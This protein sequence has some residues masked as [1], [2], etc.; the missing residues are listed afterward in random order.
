[1][2][3][4]RLIAE[5]SRPG[6][7]PFAVERIEVRQTHISVVF[8]A[9]EFVYKVKKPVALGFL[10]FST[11]EK[12]RHFC[13]EEVRLNRRLAPD[14]YLGVVPV[15]AGQRGLRFEGEGEP[16]EWAVKMCRL[17]E[18]ATLERRV[19]SGQVNTALIEVLARRLAAFHAAAERGPRIASFGRFESVAANVRGNFPPDA[20]QYACI[21]PAATIERVR[22][23]T[24]EAL[25]QLRPLIEERAA[26]GVPCDTHGDL[27]LDHVY[28]FPD[29]E[30]PADLIMIDCIEFNEQ[31]RF[32]DPVAD[33]AFLIMDLH[34]HGETDLGRTLAEAYFEAAGDRQGRALLRFYAAYRSAVRGKVEA[35]ELGEKE[36]PEFER[37]DALWRARAHWLLALALLERPERRPCLI[38]VGGLPGT[39][40][41]TLARALD[42][43]AGLEV[44]RTDAVR[45]ELAGARG[46]PARFGEGIYTAEWNDRTYAEVARQAEVGLL[47]GGR[48]LVDAAFGQ[49]LRRQAFLDLAG[50]LH[51]PVFF[52]HCQADPDL[53]RQRL[54][55]RRGDVSDADWSVYVEAARRWEEPG[56]S[57]R[58]VWH[59]VATGYAPDVLV[60]RAVAVLRERDVVS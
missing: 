5:L 52:F 32:T 15:V 54:A 13:E 29:R 46:G 35:I 59:D 1:M 12:R 58:A 7:Y 47:E 50:R 30:P 11:L 3:L 31:F 23:V 57:T 9:G 38:L 28:W 40:K 21:L 20:R 19:E 42:E 18:Q 49:E 43:C 16:C 6:A 4:N 36:I 51:V 8:L 33:V 60:A 24:E 27:H 26:R 2:E 56:A 22:A 37:A 39:G 34:F 41:S 14:V 45:K 10:D 53:V 17:P 55:G 44:I 25:S 48:I